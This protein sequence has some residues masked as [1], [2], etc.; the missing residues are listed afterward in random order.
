MINGNIAE[1]DINSNGIAFDHSVNDSIS[2]NTVL[3]NYMKQHFKRRRKERN[4]KERKKTK[5]KKK[6]KKKER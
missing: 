6:K 4:E 5:R 3:D 2:V 1:N